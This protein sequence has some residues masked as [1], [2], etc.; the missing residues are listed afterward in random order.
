MSVGD[1][2][3]VFDD[4]GLQKPGREEFRPKPLPVAD[5]LVRGVNNIP[6]HEPSLHLEIKDT[7]SLE[8]PSWL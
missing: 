5:L 7:P 6:E 2:Q 8:K 4:V 1:E 3:D